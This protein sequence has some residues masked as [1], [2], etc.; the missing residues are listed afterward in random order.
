MRL[1]LEQHDVGVY[2]Q[3]SGSVSGANLVHHLAWNGTRLQFTEDATAST[4][5]LR[6]LTTTGIV[7]SSSS[8]D[9]TAGTNMNGM[10]TINGTSHCCDR[11]DGDYG[12]MSTTWSR[13]LFTS[14]TCVNTPKC[15]WRGRRR[16]RPED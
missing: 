13:A 8:G 12:T 4:Q 10:S 6:T 16:R 7:A 11:L 3:S 15:D 2:K 14:Y 5:N 9:F 1:R